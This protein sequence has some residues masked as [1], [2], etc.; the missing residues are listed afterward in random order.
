MVVPEDL[1]V[2]K[3]TGIQLVVRDK[4]EVKEFQ[5]QI[6]SGNEADKFSINKLTGVLSV[7]RELDY[8]G[9]TY[10]RTVRI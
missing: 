10:D 3:D 5:F 2:G 4:D 9:P 8:D 6:V 7:K 1:E